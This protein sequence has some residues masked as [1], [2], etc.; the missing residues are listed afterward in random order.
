M[1]QIE[2]PRLPPSPNMQESSTEPRDSPTTTIGQYV[3]LVRLSFPRIPSDT[4]VGAATASTGDT[5]D[6]RVSDANIPSFVPFSL[7]SV[8]GWCLNKR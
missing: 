5:S 6:T 2:H 4:V 1:A 3:Y 8:V 7:K